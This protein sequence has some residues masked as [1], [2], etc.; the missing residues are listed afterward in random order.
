VTESAEDLRAGLAEQTCQ[1]KTRGDRTRPAAR[2]AGEGVYALVQGGRE[3]RL[4]YALELPQ[5]PGP[6]QDE[7]GIASEGAFVLAIKNPKKS[8]PRSAGLPDDEKADYTH[9]VQKRFRGRRFAPSHPTLLDYE[10]AEF[11]LIGGHEN[12]GETLDV[13]LKPQRESEGSADVLKKLRLKRSEHL[14]K[15][16]FEGEWQ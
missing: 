3:M 1:T 11:I 2:P 16:L 10:G 7:L 15:P 5:E 9:D 12:V 8:S 13:G 14:R 4:A 6:V